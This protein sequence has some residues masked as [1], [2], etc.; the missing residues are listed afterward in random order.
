MGTSGMQWGDLND[1]LNGMRDVLTIIVIEC[2]VLL[3]VAYYLNQ[4]A[5]LGKGISRNNPLC[6]LQC[7]L[8]KNPFN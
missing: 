8:M 7:F 1:S 4:G 5:S 2:L 6:S 3:P